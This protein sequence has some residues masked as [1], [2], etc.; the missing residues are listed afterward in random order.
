MSTKFDIATSMNSIL[1]SHEHQT[2][3][4]KPVPQFTKTAAKKKG[5]KC[6]K[7][8]CDPCECD[9]IEKEKKKE[10]KEKEK[11]KAE[12]AKAKKPAKKKASQYETCV[13]GL[14]KISEMLDSVGLAK[15]SSYTLLALDQLVSRAQTMPD[16]R[17]DN[18][19]QILGINASEMTDGVIDLD[20]DGLLILSFKE[21]G[22]AAYVYN[23]VQDNSVAQQLLKLGVK[24]VFLSAGDVS[25]TYD[26][27][28]KTTTTPKKS[29]SRKSSLISRG[30]AMPES[31]MD[32]ANRILGL[33]GTSWVASSSS[34]RT[35]NN[36]LDLSFKSGDDANGV[37]T[38]LGD[39][40]VIADLVKAIPGL[41]SVMISTPDAVDANGTPLPTVLD[42]ATGQW[43]DHRSKAQKQAALRRRF[44]TRNAQ[45]GVAPQGDKLDFSSADD[46][47]DFSSAD[48]CYSA[49]KK[50]KKAKKVKKAPVGDDDMVSEW[51]N[52]LSSR[53]L[54]P[55]SPEME[56]LM[57]GGSDD[58]NFE[59]EDIDTLL[60]DL[61]D[62]DDADDAE[63]SSDVSEWFQDL[64]RRS[65]DPEDPAYEILDTGG[66]DD[67]LSGIG[68][69]DVEA[70][71][72]GIKKDPNEF[73]FTSLLHGD[74][75]KDT[76]A[77]FT[78][79]SV[80]GRKLTSLQK[81][82]LE[83]RGTLVAQ[84]AKKKVQ[85]RR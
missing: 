47:L 6:P 3:F 76:P 9:K 11:A 27:T 48:D 21:K 20:R 5:E 30:Q 82:A 85:R 53:L 69:D 80:A 13:I 79:Q 25:G 81:L 33:S 31:K 57:D 84:G 4:A 29:A 60:A 7:C 64:M 45:A 52:N 54:D 37:V 23:L 26:L 18:V 62:A 49:D 40:K 75:D 68:D 1:G 73:S 41:K 10:E 12:K 38:K 35:D 63:D 77:D 71:F 50:G 39:K 34:Y 43:T 55:R 44:L 19:Q 17:L 67:D 22:R 61:H 46:K 16:N 24:K 65:I 56:T 74:A 32:A 72:S 14:A 78:W 83:L 15:A 58:T 42:V 8:K 36:A 66:K 70:A 28:T 2:I 51:Y 59:D